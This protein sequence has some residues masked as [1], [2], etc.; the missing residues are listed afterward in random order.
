M[1]KWIDARVIEVKKWKYPL[2]SLILHAKISPFIAGQFA[3]IVI[4]KNEKKIQRAYSYVNS[5]KDKNL[6]FYIA[7]IKNGKITNALY[8]LMPGNNIV[9]SKKSFGF[10]T[11]KEVPQTENLWMISTGTAIGPYLSMLQDGGKEIKK[12]KKIILIHAVRYINQLNYLNVINKIKLQY[13]SKFI[14]Q[15]IVSR[16]KNKECLFGRIPKLLLNN[17]IEKKIHVKINSNNTHIMLCGNPSMLKN[18]YKVLKE[19]YDLQKNL[20]RRKGHITMENY[21]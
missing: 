1:T 21:W 13:G 11:L 17:E 3:K 2:F 20:R 8:K 14:F 18:T 5:P 7:C 4:F 15:K 10:F 16:E 6:E 9:I 12:F 19:K